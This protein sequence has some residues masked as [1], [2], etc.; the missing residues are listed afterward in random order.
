MPEHS[1]V[2]RVLD[3]FFLDGSPLDADSVA[4]IDGA[5]PTRRLERMLAIYMNAP[6]DEI[7]AEGIHE[8]RRC[9]CLMGQVCRLWA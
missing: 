8:M 2:R 5:A 6:W 7:H 1:R 3:R 4:Y 9:I